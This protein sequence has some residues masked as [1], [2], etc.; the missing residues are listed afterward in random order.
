M[1]HLSCVVYKDQ[2][3]RKEE[4]YNNKNGEEFV[5]LLVTKNVLIRK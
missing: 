3:Q 2:G 4:W 1:V 5:T